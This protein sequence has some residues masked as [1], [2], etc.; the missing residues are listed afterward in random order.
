LTDTALRSEDIEP[1]LEGHRI[2]WVVHAYGSVASTNDTARRLADGGSPEGTLVIAE[3][4]TAGRGRRGSIWESPPGGLWFSMVL[5]PGLP[6]ERASGISVV[7]GVSV[8]RAVA[9]VSGLPARIKWPNDVFVSGG[10]LAGAM[11]TAVGEGGLV[12]GVGI[13]V[14]I[15]RD[16]LPSLEW[17]R[18]TSLL[19]E[20][21]RA[22]DRAALLALVLRRFEERYIAYRGPDHEGLIDEW[23]ELS[24][25]L[26]EEVVAVAGGEEVRGTVF[27]LE[28]DGGLVLRLPDGRHR[29]LAPTGDVTLSVKG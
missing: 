18:A 16:A 25:V 20:S 29:K 5:R 12:A 19:A 15:E 1:L 10:K 14:N 8:A 6:P 22:F 17:Y 27:G 3:T 28:D 4:Q 24:L 13:N 21:G 9:E 26:G 7:A 2:R 11:L 23:R